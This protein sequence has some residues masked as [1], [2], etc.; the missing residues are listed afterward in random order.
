AS[1]ELT[2]TEEDRGDESLISEDANANQNVS[3]LSCAKEAKRLIRRSLSRL[4][5]LNL[6]PTRSE[7]KNAASRTTGDVGRSCAVSKTRVDYKLAPRAR[8]FSA[9]DFS[10]IEQVRREQT[11]GVVHGAPKRIRSS[12]VVGSLPGGHSVRAGETRETASSPDGTNAGLTLPNIG[13]DRNLNSLAHGGKLQRG[14]LVASH[15]QTRSPPVATGKPCSNSRESVK[16]N[17]CSSRELPE[18]GNRLNLPTVKTPTSGIRNRN[19]SSS[20]R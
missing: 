6:P 7:Q 20:K 13:L 5:S 11:K 19:E 1:N 9:Y 8:N 2:D 14:K 15:A 12:G 17:S 3:P 4:N 16:E 10:E 18:N